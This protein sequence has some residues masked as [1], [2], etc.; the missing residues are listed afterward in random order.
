VGYADEPDGYRG[1]V[2][3]TAAELPLNDSSDPERRP[4]GGANGERRMPERPL[5]ETR[6][7]G[8]HVED[9]GR[10]VVLGLGK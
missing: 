2:A 8:Q 10:H 6:R 3:P 1:D 9:K 4:S 7:T 5:Y